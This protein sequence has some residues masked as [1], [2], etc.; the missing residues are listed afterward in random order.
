M[1]GFWLVDEGWLSVLRGGV[2]TRQQEGRG[3]CKQAVDVICPCL[4]PVQTQGRRYGS[5]WFFLAGEQMH[6][7][8]TVY[9]VLQIG[10]QRGQRE[11]V[12]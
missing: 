7:R 12:R 5:D 4:C 3:L 11:Q 2:V 9:C 8:C 6:L 1:T 10:K